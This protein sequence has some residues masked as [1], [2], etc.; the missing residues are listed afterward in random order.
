MKI[1]MY[2]SPGKIVPDSTIRFVI[3]TQHIL[4]ARRHKPA[5]GGLGGILTSANL[6]GN[7][8]RAIPLTAFKPAW[9]D[10]NGCEGVGAEG[11]ENWDQ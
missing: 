2:N 10:G 9:L 4:L 5:R 8:V 7:D 3:E 11:Q 1:G 6:Q